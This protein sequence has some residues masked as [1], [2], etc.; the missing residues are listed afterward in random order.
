VSVLDRVQHETAQKKQ[1]DHAV[2]T[3]A[4]LIIAL[5]REQRAGALSEMIAKIDLAEAEE[6]AASKPTNEPPKVAS[7]G[8]PP[9]EKVE[10]DGRS[11]V[12]K[13]EEYIR[14]HPEGVRTRDVAKAIGQDVSNVDGTLRILLKRGDIVRD[15]KNRKWYPANAPA[16]KPETK[17]EKMTIRELIYAVF[18]VEKAPLGAAALYKGIQK[19]KP[20]INRSSVDGEI[21]RMKKEHP[22]LIVAVGTAPHGGSLYNLATG[23]GHAGT[24]AN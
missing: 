24:A 2:N 16:Q 13:A 18:A 15:Q 20:E 3:A 17:P 19:I 9:V 14:A 11:F 22:P 5:P 8:A 23:G 7:N 21:N 10:T 4:A 6:A 12:E 1:R